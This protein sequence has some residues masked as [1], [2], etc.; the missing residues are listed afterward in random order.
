MSPA[1]VVEAAFAPLPA[2]VVEVTASTEAQPRVATGFGMPAPAA[3]SPD[4]PLYTEQMEL[5]EEGLHAM[6]TS[7]DDDDVFM[8]NQAPPVPDTTLHA[9]PTLHPRDVVLAASSVFSCEDT[10]SLVPT[11]L[12][13]F[14]TTMSTAELTDHLEWLWLMRTDIATRTR[15]AALRGHLLRQPSERTLSELIRLLEIFA[16]DFE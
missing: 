3:A 12:S 16:A 11:I 14:V 9:R 8:P 2:Q 15:D 7:S 4:L 1:A 13:T 10:Q 5:Q 6:L